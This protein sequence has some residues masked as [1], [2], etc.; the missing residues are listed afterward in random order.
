MYGDR[1]SIFGLERFGGVPALRL[2]SSQ[3]VVGGPP[4][5]PRAPLRRHRGRRYSPSISAYSYS[6]KFR[7]ECCGE[8]RL[9]L[10]GQ[11]ADRQRPAHQWAPKLE[12]G[13]AATSDL[14]GRDGPGARNERPH[15]RSRQFRTDA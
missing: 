4:A 11:G 9:R 14:V 5:G 3:Q 10:G 8:S 2:A 6:S 12:R 13:F 7:T 15:A 1:G